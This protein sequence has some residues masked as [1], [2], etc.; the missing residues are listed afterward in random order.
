MAKIHKNPI[1]QGLSGKLG[2]QIMFRR[3]RDGRT[4]VCQAPDFS[5]RVLSTE[6]KAHHS[7]FKEGAAYAKSAAKTQPI[8]AELAAGTMK[9]AYNVA[10]ADFFH[11]PVIHSLERAGMSLKICA[12]DNVKVA[13]VF[14]MVWDEAG[15]ILQKGEATQIE[16]EAWTYPLQQAG[17]FLVEV[18][19]LAGNV[20]TA[21]IE[22]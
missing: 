16:E 15:K 18:R 10:L 12:S 17:R 4:I 13:R 5:R 19:D 9:T 7:R 22:G 3:L 20:V 8:Y 14:V 11:P 1:V 2:D 21:E 6:Q